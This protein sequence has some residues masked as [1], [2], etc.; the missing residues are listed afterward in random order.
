LKRILTSLICGKVNY[1]E[2]TFPRD[3]DGRDT[4]TQSQVRV[5]DREKC[6]DVINYLL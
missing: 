1:K 6:A 2:E 5:T 3:T 4:H